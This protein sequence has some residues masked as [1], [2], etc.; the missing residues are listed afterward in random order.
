MERGRTTAE[1]VRRWR[2]RVARRLRARDERRPG[3]GPCPVP[4]RVWADHPGN[5]EAV[6]QADAFEAALAAAYG[7]PA[8]F[9]HELDRLLG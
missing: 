7:N 2:D 1:F 4:E 6:K 9:E 5:P 3:V 8:R